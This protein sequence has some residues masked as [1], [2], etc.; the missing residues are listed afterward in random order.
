MAFAN[1]F[2]KT[3]MAASEVLSGV[4]PDSFRDLLTDQQPAVSWDVAVADS[5]EGCV[6]VEMAVNLAARLYPTLGLLAP[7]GDALA[8]DMA[9][10]AT[11]I[12]PN[13]ELRS[14]AAGSTVVLVAGRRPRGVPG[15]SI[16]FGSDGWVARVSDKSAIPSGKSGN[17]LGAAAAACIASANAFRIGFAKHLQVATPDR[18]LRISLLDFSV[19]P[20]ASNAPWKA[21]PLGTA[22]LIGCGAIGSAVIWV[23]A[24]A[25][26]LSGT[27]VVVD[28]DSCEL[29]NLQRYLL[30]TQL[31]DKRPKVDVA[32]S[33][34][35]GTRFLVAPHNCE[36]GEYLQHVR[37]W[38]F[39]R[40]LV[41]VDSVE[42]R[43]AIQAS[44]PRWI[45]NGWTQVGDLGVSRHQF[46]GP[47]P[48]LM[49]LYFPEAGG[50]SHSE[51]VALDLGLPQLE[52]QVRNMLH[53]GIPL[54]A[55]FLQQIA[56]AKQVSVEPLLQFAGQ[57]L[58]VFHSRA[59][60]GG[61]VVALGGKTSIAEQ[62]AVP[63]AFQSALAGVM[64]AAEWIVD[65]GRLRSGRLPATTRIDVLHPLGSELSVPE[66]KHIDCI[67][68]DPDY[69]KQYR[70]KFLTRR[71][72]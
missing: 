1:F 60:C 8:G 22:H 53:L 42:D 38:R 55:S 18:N 31:D 67:C 24:R 40:L 10:L 63:L 44:L 65:A 52:P 68:C 20:K 45:A 12:N 48:C 71:I 64:L 30:L 66:A 56:A 11:S 15:V 46:D 33:A 13:I 5:Q 7:R 9:A 4:S 49:C 26:G 54:D 32:V 35:E 37:D 6:A 50:R 43:R 36:W 34:L 61:M 51:L 69:Q 28:G 70:R 47:G 25:K 23:L 58:D 72:T 17:P 59:I 14:E 16:F 41:A 27:V 19:G 29:S 3:L 2:D 57:P 39:E 62:A 21:R